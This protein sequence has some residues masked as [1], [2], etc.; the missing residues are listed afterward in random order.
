[1]SHK[2]YL[3]ILLVGLCIVS[4]RTVI[5]CIKIEINAKGYTTLSNMI[6]AHR[7]YLCYHVPR[8]ITSGRSE[9][10]IGQFPLQNSAISSSLSSQALASS[11][12]RIAFLNAFLSALFLLLTFAISSP[13]LSSLSSRGALLVTLPTVGESCSVELSGARVTPPPS[14][15]H[16]EEVWSEEEICTNNGDETESFIHVGRG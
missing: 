2:P 7:N 12:F 5:Y 1:M 13:S 14:F 10:Q 4:D 8:V 6:F 11:S 9:P 16:I 15:G 3:V